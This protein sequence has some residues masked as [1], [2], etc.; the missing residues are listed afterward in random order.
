MC[1]CVCVCVPGIWL[2]VFLFPSALP[3]FC[4][5]IFLLFSSFYFLFA[6]GG[7]KQTLGITTAF[8]SF[9]V[10]FFAFFIQLESIANN[11]CIVRRQ[12]SKNGYA[13]E[14]PVRTISRL[15][16]SERGKRSLA[17][18]HSY[19]AQHGGQVVA[20]LVVSLSQS[21]LPKKKFKKLNHV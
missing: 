13:P 12:A 7:H 14:Y 10:L 1:V 4:M 5:V 15:V 11:V 20:F 17:K 6:F 9:L 19:L 8:F 18:T 3:Y 16:E 21:M 2:R